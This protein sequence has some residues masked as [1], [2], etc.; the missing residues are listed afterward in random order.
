MDVADELTLSESGEAVNVEV[1]IN[2][3]P[4]WLCDVT[5]D[6]EDCEVHITGFI[7]MKNEQKCYKVE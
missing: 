3:P 2:V 5:I 7:E 1:S 6:T 4:S